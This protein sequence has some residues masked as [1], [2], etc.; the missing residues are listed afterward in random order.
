MTVLG[1]VLLVLAASSYLLA[2]FAGIATIRSKSRRSSRWLWQ[3]MLIGALAIVAAVFAMEWALLSHDFSIAYVVRNHQRA[4]PV[5]Y[6][7]ASLWGALEGSILLWALVVGVGF[8]LVAIRFRRQLADELVVWTLVVGAGIAFFFAGLMVSVANPFAATQGAIP[9]DGM[10]M[11]PLLRN[12][13]LMVVHPPMLYVGYAGFSVP[14]AFAAAALITGRL[15]EGWLLLTRRATLIAWGFL[16]LGIIMGA[17][18]SYEVLGWGGYWAWDPVENASLLPW[19]TGTAYLHSVVIQERRAML[20]VWNLSLLLATYC[21]TI[22]GTF[23]TRSGVVNSVHAFSESSIGPALLGFLAVVSVGGIVLIASRGE[24]LRSPGQIDSPVSREAAFLANNFVLA[25]LAFVVLLGTV[26]PLVAEAING[27][28]LSVGEPYFDRLGMPLGLAILFLMAVTPLLPWRAGLTQTAKDRI[29]VPAWI[30]GTVMVIAAIGGIR[31]IGPVLTLGLGAFA[32]A[33]I[34][35][36]FRQGWAGTRSSGRRVA[37]RALAL[38]R[39]HPRRYGGLVVHAGVVVVA[40]AIAGSQSFSRHVE[41]ELSTGDEVQIASSSPFADDYTIRFDGVR[42]AT[43]AEQTISYATLSVWRDEE[44]LGTYE[45][46]IA[47]FPRAQQAIGTPA[48]RTGLI[49]DLYLTVVRIPDDQSGAV[50]IGVGINPM[51]LWLWLGGGLM[52]IGT[53][54]ALVPRTRSGSS[55]PDAGGRSV[56]RSTDDDVGD[57][58]RTVDSYRGTAAPVGGGN[59][60]PGPAQPAA[61]TTPGEP[62]P[63]A[64][65]ASNAVGSEDEEAP[66]TVTSSG[67]RRSGADASRMGS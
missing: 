47:L 36:Q 20:R 48:V 11:N 1:T 14:F 6:T 31:G 35:G 50:T 28:Q 13:I 46:A 60:E 63:V 9:A 19:L 56:Q 22:L 54:L 51:M 49:E 59:S 55:A 42:T 53:L 25:A 41:S 10:G 33:G 4:T 7:I 30:G 26:F 29:L 34:L 67:P 39:S 27:E 62:I 37:A 61:P 12:H 17:W 64:V 18:W 32:L 57:P 66:V 38:V 21:L 8:A 3:Y 16:T 65:P 43:T 40:V 58:D 44:S 24:R 2:I 45:P 5:L 15:G 23:L 52:L